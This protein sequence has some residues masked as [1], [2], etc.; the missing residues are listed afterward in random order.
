MKDEKRIKYEKAVVRRALKILEQ[1]MNY[2]TTQFC[3][4]A[5]AK[6]YTRL[7]IGARKQEVFLVLFLTNQNKL[8]AAEEMFTGTI[9]GASVYPREIIRRALELNAAALI[10]AHNHPAG[11]IEPSEADRALTRR[12]Q[13]ACH[14]MDITLLD[15][16]VVNTYDAY[17]FAQ[18]RDL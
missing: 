17:S 7:K 16:L 14:A 5:V 13:G 15:H 4:T 11:T 10:V 9:G 6:T 18:N 3:E 1:Q 12:I 2:G 8:L